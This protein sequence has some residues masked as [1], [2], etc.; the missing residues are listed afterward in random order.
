MPLVRIRI[1]AE[2]QLNANVQVATDAVDP[3][4]QLKGLPHPAVA[5]Q[6]ILLLLRWPRRLASCQQRCTRLKISTTTYMPPL[7]AQ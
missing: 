7:C 3:P 1:M 4:P 2:V 5:F 6:M